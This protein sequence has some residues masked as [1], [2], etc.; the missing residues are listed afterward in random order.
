[1]SDT[2]TC[3]VCNKELKS[4]NATHLNRH[5]LTTASYS[6]KFPG[7]EMQ[8]ASRRE[9]SSKRKSDWNKKRWADPDYAAN[10]KNRLSKLLKKTQQDNKELFS[11]KSSRA[12]TKLNKKRWQDPAYRAKRTAANKEIAKQAWQ[13]P[14]FREKMSHRNPGDHPKYK[15]VQYKGVSFKSSWEAKT[16]QYFDDLGL[17]WSYEPAAFTAEVSHT[18]KKCYRPDFF[19]E[20]WQC[21]VEVKGWDKDDFANERAYWETVVGRPIKLYDAQTLKK[22]GII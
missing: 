17:T 1:M 10:Q 21:F 20:E 3:S 11:A 12:L 8:P 2:V 14:D 6:F 13:D 22:L 4:I 15:R 9:A 7:A 5:G 19:V 16:A 18:G